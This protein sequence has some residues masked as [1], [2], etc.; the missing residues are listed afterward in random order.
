MTAQ[1]ECHPGKSEICYQ[2][3]LSFFLNQNATLEKVGFLNQTR[4]SLASGH[5]FPNAR[6]ARIR[7]GA[8][9]Q[10]K[11]VFFFQKTN[12]DQQ[13]AP[14]A[15]YYYHFKLASINVCNPIN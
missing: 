7:S 4:K 14:N 11:F 12:C 5:V 1:D 9:S 13:L 3:L 10:N 6:R 2:D 8:F 15:L